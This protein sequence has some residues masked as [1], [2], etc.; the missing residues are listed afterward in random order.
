MSASARR[1]EIIGHG[2]AGDFFPGNSRMAIE[3]GLHLAVDRI[4]F[5]VQCSADRDI[6]LVHNDQIRVPGKGFKPVRAISTSDLRIALPGLLTLAE[7]VEMIGN[8]AQLL[9]D[10]KSPGYERELI[11]AIASL[12]VVDNTIVSSTYASVLR[13]IRNAFPSIR[14]GLSTG[15][16]ANG[17]PTKLARSLVTRTLQTATPFPFIAAL[18]LLHATDAMV[19]FRVVTP[20]LVRSLHA[21]G[22]RINTWTVNHP[23]QIHRVIAMGVDGI[24]SNRPDLVLDALNDRRS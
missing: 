9:I 12:G 1:V 7:A 5:D 24:I 11:A 18:K 8:R 16:S 22:I 3:Q 2:G 10:A 6:V 20:S 14:I 23:K 19:Q 4:E 15:H 13:S 17:I 21:R